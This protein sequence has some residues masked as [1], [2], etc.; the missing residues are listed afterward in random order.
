MVQ[1]STTNQST[2]LTQMYTA[3]Y[4]PVNPTI[5]MSYELKVIFV[6]CDI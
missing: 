4:D 5:V 1:A 3:G 6:P 2:L